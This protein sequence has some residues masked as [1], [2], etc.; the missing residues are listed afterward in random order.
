MVLPGIYR[1]YDQNFK[2]ANIV[3]LNL[4]FLFHDTSI[5]QPTPGINCREDQ[6]G[7]EFAKL[8]IIGF[9]IEVISMEAL[10]VMRCICK[11][12]KQVFDTS[13]VFY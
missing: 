9:F 13:G 12:K 8:G 6:V 10:I 11:C 7:I 4:E 5:I 3:V 2:R 1:F